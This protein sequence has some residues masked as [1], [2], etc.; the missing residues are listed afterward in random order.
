MFVSLWSALLVISVIQAVSRCKTNSCK[1]SWIKITILFF[2]TVL[3][4]RNSERV[5]LRGSSLIYVGFISR[6]VS[7]LSHLV[8]LYPLSSFFSHASHFLG[9]VHVAFSGFLTAW[10]SQGSQLLP[11]ELVFQR[12]G[13][14]SYHFSRPRLRN[15]YVLTSAIFCW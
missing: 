5:Q 7:L 14:R 6:M 4:V 13:N 15:C 11:P 2:F 3:Q 12:A 1:T 8:P 10:Q 9:P